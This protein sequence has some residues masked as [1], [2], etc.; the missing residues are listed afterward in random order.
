MIKVK[1][2]I[3]LEKQNQRESWEELTFKSCLVK[4][5]AVR[6]QNLQQVGRYVFKVSEYKG[7]EVIQISIVVLRTTAS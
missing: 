6:Q 4:V 5:C 7:R 1:E 2:I 3:I